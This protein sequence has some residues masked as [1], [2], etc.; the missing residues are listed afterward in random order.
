MGEGTQSGVQCCTITRVINAITP[1]GD[2]MTR[3]LVM[4]YKDHFTVL[5]RLGLGKRHLSLISVL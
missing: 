3:D 1:T 4:R 5:R 2:L